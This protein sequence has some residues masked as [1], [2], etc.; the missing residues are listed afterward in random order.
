MFDSLIHWLRPAGPLRLRLEPA[1]LCICS[2]VA[3]FMSPSGAA[4]NSSLEYAVKAAYLYKF[5]LYVDWPPS[6][7]SSPDSALNLCIVGE[8]PF[9]TTLDEA[10]RNQVINGRPITIRRMKAGAP[11][12][13]CHIMYVGTGAILPTGQDPRALRGKGLLTV[14]DMPGIGIITFVIKDNRVRFDIDEDA[15]AQS[16]IGISS[17]L[18]DLALNVK[19]R[20]GV[21]RSL[22]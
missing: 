21:N 2:C 14:S 16:G 5:G 1:M 11:V 9:G 4:E 17:K 22:H 8:D 20:Q 15:A 12:T 18:L 7:F 3:L 13:G 10:V 19:P 6:A